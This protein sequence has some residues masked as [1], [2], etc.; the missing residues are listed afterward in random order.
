MK[1]LIE[2]I[3]EHVEFRKQIFKLAM[4]DIIK[5]YKGAALGWSWAL[6]KPAVQILVYW[7]VF[8]VAM[9]SASTTKGGFGVTYPYYFWRIVG[10][11]PWFYIS[12]MLTRGTN[13]IRIYSYLVTRMKFPV[14]T[15]P[16]YVS[17]SHLIIN[18]GITI[19][20]AIMYVCMGFSID[21]Y[22]LQLPL[23]IFLAY[24]FFTVMTLLFSMLC[25]MSKD[26]GNLIK[27]FVIALFWF[28]GVIWKTNNHLINAMLRMNPIYYICHGFRNVFIYKVWIWQEPKR[29]MYFMIIFFVMSIM[30]L[31]VYK[32]L[33]KEIPDVL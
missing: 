25:A 16:T 10:L 3:K 5:T 26:F 13:A 23:Y 29:F 11:V 32:K 18:I 17:I 12:D 27:S 30:A 20:M 15:I 4:A 31:R 7:F 21:V 33:R 1:T 28:S 24:M 2:I 19:I 22:F 14:S 8:D 9:A 6:I